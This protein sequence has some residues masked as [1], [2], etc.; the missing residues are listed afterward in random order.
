[1]VKYKIIFKDGTGLSLAAKLKIVG[2]LIGRSKKVNKEAIYTAMLVINSNKELITVGKLAYTYNCSPRTIYR[3]MGA[4]LKQ[5]KEILNKQ[6][7]EKI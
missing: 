1:M 5:E 6:I 2:G 7:Y 3:N 4:E